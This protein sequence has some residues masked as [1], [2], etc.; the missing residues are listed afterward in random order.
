MAKQTI[1]VSVRKRTLKAGGK[2]LKLE[3]NFEGAGVLIVSNRPRE[4][5]LELHYRKNENFSQYREGDKVY[6][7]LNSG[8]KVQ[9]CS[10]QDY[11]TEV[12]PAVRIV[13]EY[14]IKVHN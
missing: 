8:A 5:I 1:E 2:T 10:E 11:T 13:G 4:S 12:F 14:N 3:D 7:F 9:A 6:A